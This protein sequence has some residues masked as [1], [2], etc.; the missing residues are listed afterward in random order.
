MFPL[1]LLCAACWYVGAGGFTF[2][3]FVADIFYRR[4]SL[5]VVDM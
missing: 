3:S 5:P 4:C 1:F 2:F